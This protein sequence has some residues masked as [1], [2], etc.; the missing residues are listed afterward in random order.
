MLLGMGS[1]LEEHFD[2]VTQNGAQFD[3]FSKNKIAVVCSNVAVIALTLT[4]H[5]LL[6][7]YI[8]QW[9]AFCIFFPVM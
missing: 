4:I 5:S 9:S 8:H 2:D 7:V 3:L 1:A 6:R